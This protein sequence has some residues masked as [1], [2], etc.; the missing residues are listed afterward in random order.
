M[1]GIGEPAL[2]SLLSIR[3]GE[4]NQGKLQGVLTSLVTLASVLGLLI[5]P[6]LYGLLK[7]IWP[8]GIWM[9]ALLL[10]AAVIPVIIFGERSKNKPS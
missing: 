7:P 8:G 9:I 10:Y 2:Q 3:V 5:F 1:G 4:D 6:A